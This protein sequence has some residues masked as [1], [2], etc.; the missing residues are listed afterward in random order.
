MPGV[1]AGTTERQASEDEG[2]VL[3]STALVKGGI[4]AAHLPQ[5]SRGQHEVESVE[6]LMQPWAAEFTVTL[7]S[8]LTEPTKVSQRLAIVQAEFAS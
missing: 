5:P 8:C 3:I 7:V 4:P 2:L 6:H 1:P